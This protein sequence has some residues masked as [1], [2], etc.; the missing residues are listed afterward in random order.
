MEPE[1]HNPRVLPIVILSN[2]HALWRILQQGQKEMCKEMGC[3]QRLEATHS[4][5][6]RLD[7]F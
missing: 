6:Q 7:F 2:V 1:A 3:P 4:F 5:I